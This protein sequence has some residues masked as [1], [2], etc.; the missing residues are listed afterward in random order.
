MV[1]LRIE[2][3][4]VTERVLRRVAADEFEEENEGVLKG[5]LARSLEDIEAGRVVEWEEIRRR[6][7]L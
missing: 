4:E 5:Q 7:G 1:T 3:D 6:H 2:V